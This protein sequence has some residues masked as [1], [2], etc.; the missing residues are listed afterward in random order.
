MADLNDINA[1]LARRGV[2]V[3]QPAQASPQQEQPQVQQETGGNPKNIAMRGLA[4]IL[5]GVAEGGQD[6][7]NLP[8]HVTHHFAPETADRIAATSI[9]RRLF[10]PETTDRSGSFGVNNPNAWD[11]IVQEMG[12]TAAPAAATG[13]M[14]I[15]SLI[16]RGA[17]AGALQGASES[18]DPLFGA[19]LGGAIGALPGLGQSMLPGK[20]AK[21]ITDLLSEESL[22]KIKAPSKA[23]YDKA[24]NES[25]GINI[26][27]DI[28]KALAGDKK[29]A[30]SKLAEKY[31]EN[32]IPASIKYI[33]LNPKEVN[34]AYTKSGLKRL[35]NRFM[36]NPTLQNAHELQ[37]QLGTEV[38]ALKAKELNTKSLDAADNAAL[39]SYQYARKIIKNDINGFLEGKGKGLAEDYKNATLMHAKD[40]VPYRNAAAIM[41]EHTS[42]EEG[43]NQRTFSRAILKASN[44]KQLAKKPIPE[45]IRKQAIE[46]KR[47]L[48]YKD[49]ATGKS[50][51]GMLRKIITGGV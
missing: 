13:L 21:K 12:R 10:A 34:V 47:R 7:R 25:E 24:F 17:T 19:A 14:G 6:L 29:V 27:G 41:Q 9:G 20:A 28:K 38:R 16:A 4:D 22:A 36:E 18:Q 15:N 45:D 1:E 51:I 46:L 43:L 2:G 8:Y 33:D 11:Q 35:H 5:T 26:Y 31:N 23:L 30:L 44:E 42:P 3:E 39:D 32:E 50:P 40:V 37:S 49:F 48:A